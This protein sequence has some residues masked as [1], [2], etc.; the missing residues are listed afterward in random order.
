MLAEAFHRSV[1][2]LSFKNTDTVRSGAV[3]PD[4]AATEWFLG[5][6]I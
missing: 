3:L 2:A 6:S 5:S 1:Q 4:R